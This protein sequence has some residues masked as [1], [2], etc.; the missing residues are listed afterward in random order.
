MSACGCTAHIRRKIPIRERVVLPFFLKGVTSHLNVSPLSLE[1]Y[2]HHGC[3]RVELTSHHL[4]WDP[5]TDVYEDQENAM[6]SYKGDIVC[7]GTVKRTHLTSINS[8]TNST[9]ADAVDVLSADNFATAL[10]RNVNV[11]HVKVHKTHTVSRV[12]STPNLGNVYS[13]RG[14]EVDSGT[15]SKRWNINQRKALNTVRQT[16]QRGVRSCLHPSLS[17]RMPTN[18]RMLRYKRL[19]HPVFS[20]T[21]KAGVLS[22]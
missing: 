1:E 2:E 21:M 22:A 9:C 19:P 16:T 13:T 10:E 15:L 11:S 8:V 6:L 18:D 7:P 12:E 14:K 17:R 5:G 20:D 3:P 4:K